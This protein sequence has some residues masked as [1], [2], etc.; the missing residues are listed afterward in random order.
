[1]CLDLWG[2]STTS[3]VAEVDP[4]GPTQTGSY[5]LYRG[6]CWGSSDGLGSNY[7]GA[8][9]C[10]SACRS[11]GYGSAKFYVSNGYDYLGFRLVCLP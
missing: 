1:M 11:S 3:T 2:A 4:V 8:R 10:R 9:H 6:G 5:R 7:S